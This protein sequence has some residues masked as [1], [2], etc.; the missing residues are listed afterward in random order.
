MK[1]NKSVGT[2]LKKDFQQLMMI[3]QAR[4]ST[5]IIK[6]NMIFGEIRINQ[7]FLTPSRKYNLGTIN[8]YL[9]RVNLNLK[10]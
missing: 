7:Q 2:S 9:F 5:S 4:R 3:G 8:Y 1:T 6:A 10:N